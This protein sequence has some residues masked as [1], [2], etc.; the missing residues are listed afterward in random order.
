MKSIDL[1][2]IKSKG[3]DDLILDENRN[4]MTSLFTQT[5]PYIQ[6]AEIIG[7]DGQRQK[8]QTLKQQLDEELKQ[9]PDSDN[10]SGFAPHDI[11]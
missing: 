6:L 10:G 2:I 11:L 1:A 5:R 7:W 8:L 9:K 4:M 3:S